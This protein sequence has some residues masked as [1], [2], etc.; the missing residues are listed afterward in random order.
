[1][2]FGDAGSTV[3]TYF[4]VGGLL[5]LLF[6]PKGGRRGS[7]ETGVA[8]QAGGGYGSQTAMSRVLGGTGK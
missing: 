1:M 5:I 6:V 2:E 4:F 8:W 3:V 7:L